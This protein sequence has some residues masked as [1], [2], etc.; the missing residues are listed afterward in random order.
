MAETSQP[1]WPSDSGEPAPAPAP[2]GGPAGA[3]RAVL[4]AGLAAAAVLLGTAL[5][6][7][8]AGFIWSAVA[9]RPLLVVVAR[10][11]A[12]VVNPETAAFIVADVWFT[13]LAL[14]GGVL[15]GLLGY[16]YAVRRHGPAAMLSVLLGALAAALIARWIGEQSGAATF[17][18]LLIVS[19]PGTLLR[20]PPAL[21]GVGALAFWPLAAGLTAGGIEAVRYFRD[22]RN[23]AEQPRHRAESRLRAASTP[24]PPLRF[25]TSD[26]GPPDHA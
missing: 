5:L 26:G 25:K 16:L 9:P 12:D 2:G 18:H 21:G 20:A 15:S 14:I 8:A 19:R 11:S 3:D 13:V 7:V 1:Q 6:G 24:A 10:G 4:A 22:R 17:N 23:L